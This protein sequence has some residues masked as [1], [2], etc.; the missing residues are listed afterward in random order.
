MPVCP[1]FENYLLEP[2]ENGLTHGILGDGENGI[3][4]QTLVKVRSF[5]SRSNDEKLLFLPYMYLG[6][7]GF[8]RQYL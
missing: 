6:F 4:K 5:R 3:R 2:L 8:L 7:W 1:S